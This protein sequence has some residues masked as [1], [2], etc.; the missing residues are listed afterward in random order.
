[1]LSVQNKHLAFEDTEENVISHA[2]RRGGGRRSGSRRGGLSTGA[3]WALG[4][5]AATAGIALGRN[6]RV[7]AAVGKVAGRALKSKIGRRVVKGAR[8]Y[9]KRVASSR[10][11]KGA[12]RIGA[13]VAGSRAGQFV[14][15]RVASMKRIAVAGRGAAGRVYRRASSSVSSRAKGIK[16]SVSRVYRSASRST[17]IRAYRPRRR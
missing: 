9:G 6:R 1:M 8:L 13:R 15:R 12:R 4:V 11:V 3:R 10:A 16:R 2:G 17:R 7:R 14:G 5:G